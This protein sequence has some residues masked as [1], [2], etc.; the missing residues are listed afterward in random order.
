MAPGG[1]GPRIHSTSQ[2]VLPNNREGGL[3]MSLGGCLAER[4]FKGGGV[5][6]WSCGG[7]HQM[8]VLTGQSLGDGTGV[9]AL[10]VVGGGYVVGV[11]ALGDGAQR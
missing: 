1:G 2:G 10:A 5:I 11:Q 9:P 4:L 8:G 3:W 6:T 7:A